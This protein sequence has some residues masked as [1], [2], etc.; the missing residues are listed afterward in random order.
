MDS[1][2][3]VSNS[4]KVSQMTDMSHLQQTYPLVDKHSNQKWTRNEDVFPIENGDSL[5]FR[6]VSLPEGGTPSMCHVLG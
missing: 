4:L 2:R 3:I 6:R 5:I 1:Y